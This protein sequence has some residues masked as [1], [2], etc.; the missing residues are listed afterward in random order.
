MEEV[1]KEINYK[2]VWRLNKFV[3]SLEINI[4]S[5]QR[6]L[7]KFI[8]VFLDEN[9]IPFRI[10]LTD[11]DDELNNPQSFKGSQV[12]HKLLVLDK[13]PLKIPENKNTSHKSIVFRKNK[14]TGQITFHSILM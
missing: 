1:L 10:N 7:L 9:K 14:F 3:N 6:D 12:P 8:D 13:R 5:K 2:Y 4:T 11:S